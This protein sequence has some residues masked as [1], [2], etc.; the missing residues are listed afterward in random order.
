M[1][2]SFLITLL[3]LVSLHPLLAQ[4]GKMPARLYLVNKLSGVPVTDASVFTPTHSF[5]ALTDETGQVKLEGLP[6]GETILVIS[7]I[8]FARQEINVAQLP[9]DGR[10]V[11]VPQISSLSEVMVS[12]LSR[13]G[14]FHTISDLDIHVRPIANS[15]EVLRMVPGLFIGQHAGGGK[16]E[17]IFLRG[18]DIDHGTDINITV[19]GLPVNMVSH[20]HGQGYADLHFVI[21]ELIDKVNFNKGP[22]F[23]DKG[24]MATAGYV[25]FRT[26]D[27]LDQ[28]FVKAEAGQFNTFRTVMGVN[29]LPVI[30]NKPRSRSLYAAGELSYTDGYFDSPQAFNRINGIIKYHAPLGDRSV[31]TSYVSAFTS[32]WNASGQVPDRAVKSGDIGWYGAIDDKEGGRT[33][34]YNATAELLTRFDNGAQWR[35]QFYYSRYLFT[36]YSNFTF[37]LNDPVNGDQIRQQ[38]KRNLA[39]YLSEYSIGHSIGKH[40]AQF[41]AGLQLRYDATDNSE[42]SRTKDRNT[43]TDALM[44][45]DINE[46]NAGAYL[47]EQLTLHP[48]LNITAG[49]RGDYFHNRYRD[50]LTATDLRAHSAIIS[51]KLNINWRASRSIQLYWYNG[52]GLHSNDTRVAVQQN[53]REVVT[54][55]W[56]SDLGVIVKLG[57]RAILQSAVWYLWLK[58]EFVY[59]GDE[60]VVEAGGRTQRMGVDVSLRYELLKG[61]FADA[62]LAIARPRALG[63]A[64]EES[65]LPLA[66][67]ITS[68]G[69]ITYRKLQGWNGSLRYR[70][71]GSRPANED[72][73]VMAAG[74]FICDAALNYTRPQWECGIAVQNIFD[75]KWKETQFDTESR[76]QNEPQ[77]VSEIHFTPGTPFFARVSVAVF[78]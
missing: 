19:D 11:L 30:K 77:A 1:R 29:L 45:G 23:A 28:N 3:L 4:R 6:A 31:L 18:F 62:D 51:P 43:V 65:Y 64:K 37:F 42:L 46:L 61:L 50:Q 44:Y 60:G 69:G 59:V 35:N 76:L 13:K 68:S 73:S 74:Y 26:K 67:R 21:P 25:D 14:I 54:P 36:L 40:T 72:K 22:Y 48:D 32:K 71:M 55:A 49:L 20:A 24:N 78:F 63:V 10:I 9:A 52:Q 38:E 58:Q 39:G 53:G 7:C 66:P 8:G 12:G 5:V 17:Q 56:G 34:R 15:Q 2:R 16:A 41:K 57:Q 47:Q 75:R 27:F 33:S 70:Y